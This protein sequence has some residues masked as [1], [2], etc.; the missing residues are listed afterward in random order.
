M[1][2]KTYLVV[3]LALLLSLLAGCSGGVSTEKSE[4]SKEEQV[5][6]NEESSE[7]TSEEE[8]V[9]EDSGVTII[10]NFIDAYN[11]V[12]E[13]QI[14]DALSFDPQD[15]ESG[16]YRTEFRLGAWDG[17]VGTTAT[18]GDS[19]I[20]IVSYGSHGGF[21]ENKDLRIY[22]TSPSVDELFEIFRI[23]AKVMD[24]TVTDE[25]IQEVIHHVNEYGDDNG[26][27]I[28]DME[29]GTIFTRKICEMMLTVNG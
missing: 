28:G 12:A 9:V 22:V 10:N 5:E 17:S 24:E 21:F 7:V 13:V 11:A 3:A 2:K 4:E 15:E 1:M 6:Q 26:F 23:A 27:I 8:Q 14:T 18:I 20:D 19:S 16:H 25:E 29:P